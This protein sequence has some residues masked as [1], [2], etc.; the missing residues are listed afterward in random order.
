MESSIPLGREHASAP[1]N[2]THSVRGSND[3]NL[4]FFRDVILRLENNK[5]RCLI[6][7]NDDLIY[8]EWEVIHK[9]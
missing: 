4:T 7:G 5:E 3:Y 1:V 8:V 2:E 9:V 6:C